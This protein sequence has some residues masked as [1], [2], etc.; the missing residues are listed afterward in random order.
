MQLEIFKKSLE[1]NIESYEDAEFYNKF[2]MAFQQSDTRALEV[3]SSLSTI[4]CSLFTITTLVVLIS[5]I[6]P[7]ILLLVLF[8]VTIGFIINFPLSKINHNYYKDNVF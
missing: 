3:L 1:L 2:N 5:S 7:T 4:V 8:Y 6:E